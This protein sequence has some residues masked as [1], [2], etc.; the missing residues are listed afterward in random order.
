MECRFIIRGFLGRFVA[1]AGK[2]HIVG[3]DVFVWFA[4][5]TKALGC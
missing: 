4:R 1:H 2:V 5:S 3:P